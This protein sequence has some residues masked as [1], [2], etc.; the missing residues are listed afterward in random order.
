M[1]ELLEEELKVLVIGAGGLGCE[2]LK[3]LALSAVTDITVID[4]D[5]IDVSNL[6]RCGAGGSCCR[7]SY[8]STQLSWLSL[9]YCCTYICTS[10]YL[11]LQVACKIKEAWHRVQRDPTL[12]I[13]VEPESLMLP[14]N[15]V[16]CKVRVVS[17]GPKEKPNIYLAAFA[18]YMSCCLWCGRSRTGTGQSLPPLGVMLIEQQGHL[19]STAASGFRASSSL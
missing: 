6:N 12:G 9:L 11:S 5:S 13:A 3:D 17:L 4:M 7:L 16:T 1:A 18:N 14:C 2:L 15:G 19:T 8:L 10:V